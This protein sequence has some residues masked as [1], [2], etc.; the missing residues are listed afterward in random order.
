MN[1]LL[2]YD[3]IKDSKI[4]EIKEVID[5]IEGLLFSKCTI[6]NFVFYNNNPIL[7]GNGVY[8]FFKN[9]D[10]KN[11]KYLYV[12]KCSSRSFVERTPSHFDIR[13]TGW[14]NSYLRNLVNENRDKKILV[15]E[16]NNPESNC[17][18]RE[19][20]TSLQ[21]NA[22]IALDSHRLILINFVN[23]NHNNQ[24]ISRL[25]DIFNIVLEPLNKYKT[26]RIDNQEIRI[27]KYI[28]QN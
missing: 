2:N 19:Y 3:K 14:F 28:N 11:R 5:K 22:R 4:S 12:G 16:F 10:N 27:W 9:E 25:E 15:R 21:R 24:K 20:N 1:Y 23:E 6:S 18:K 7:T 8:I 13:N 26:K 17:M